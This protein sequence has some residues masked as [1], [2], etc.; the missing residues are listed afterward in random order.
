MTSVRPA[1]TALVSRELSAT[2]S[3]TLVTLLAY[4]LPADPLAQLTRVLGPLVVLGAFGTFFV[5]GTL[6]LAQRIGVVIAVGLGLTMVVAAII[7]FVFPYLGVARPLTAPPLAVGLVVPQLACATW[8]LVRRVDP[9][10]SAFAGA[11]ARHWVWAAGLGALASLSVFG[12]ERANVGGSLVLSDVAAGVVLVLVVASIALPETRWGPPRVLLLMTSVVMASWQVPLR[13]GWV[14]GGD[15]PHEYYTAALALSQGRLPL[16]G[17]PDSYGSMLSLTVWPALWHAVAGLSLLTVFG[18]LPEVALACCVLITWGTVR[19]RVGPRATAA[20][21]ALF[22]V[23][24]PDLVSILPLV[25]RQCYALIFLALLVFSVSSVRLSVSSARVLAISAIVGTAITHYS[26]AFV[27]AAA[28][29][30]AWVFGY[31]LRA[32]ARVRVLTMRVVGGTAVAVALWDVLVA[33]ASSNLSQVAAGLTAGPGSGNLPTPVTGPGVRCTPSGAQATSALHPATPSHHRVHAVFVDHLVQLGSSSPSS[34]AWTVLFS[35]L[36]VAAIGL[37]AV[38]VWRV[39]RHGEHGG[40]LV[41]GVA[42]LVSVVVLGTADAATRVHRLSQLLARPFTTP[43]VTSVSDVARVRADDLF[44]LTHRYFWMRLSDGSCG[45]RLVSYAPPTAVGVHVLGSL[46]NGVELSASKVLVLVAIASVALC[47]AAA[48]RD[49]RIAGIAGLGVAGVAAAAA[50]KL[51]PAM[52]QYFGT[53]RIQVE[54]YLIFAVTT[55][56]AI[57]W[58]RPTWQSRT[59][60]VDLRGWS[61]A[62]WIA[63]GVVAAVAMAGS[64]GLVNLATPGRP[65]DAAYSTSGQQADL[66]TSPSELPAAE[67]IA[68]A[69]PA[70]VVQADF[71]SLGA[72]GSVGYADRIAFIPSVDPVLTDQRSWVFVSR[73]NL[74]GRAYGGS[75][76]YKAAFRFPIVFLESSRPTLFVSNNAVILGSSGVR[77]PA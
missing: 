70:G 12:L 19:E 50:W 3:L 62:G 56:A 64:M 47:V 54:T 46:A 33:R 21:C 22:V 6:S 16:K 59:A 36:T 76:T 58:L 23:T 34:M 8:C 72:L 29:V 65:L 15:L 61:S 35:V 55:A 18:I 11:A 49:K 60:R 7:G 38:A 74:A 4:A 45:V 66:A 32:P 26:T 24:A 13:G 48:V 53:D 44:T 28:L 77:T 51:L 37:L 14:A 69:R 25:S 42:A 9:V 52:A 5:R 71:T 41:V 67:W 2:I 20:I 57:E 40:W 10:R 17:Y 68:R 30:C 27:A 31:L 73:T 39:F 1:K 63:I 43:R 75:T